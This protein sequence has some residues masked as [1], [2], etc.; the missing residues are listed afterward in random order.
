MRRELKS[1]IGGAA[2][3]V[4]AACSGGNDHN[5]DDNL[6]F[7]PPGGAVRLLTV[8]DAARELGNVSTGAIISS[9][10]TTTTTATSARVA[11]K[12]RGFAAALSMSGLAPRWQARATPSPRASSGCPGGGSDNITASGTTSRSFEFFNFAGTVNYEV[13]Q[14]SDCSG[15]IAGTTIDG[16]AQSGATAD[17]SYIYALQGDLPSATPLNLFFNA[18]D[19][20]NGQT[21]A[22]RQNVLGTI[23]AQESSAQEDLRAELLVRLIQSERG[24]RIY[25][26]DFAVG[27]ASLSFQVVSGSNSAILDGPYS[28]STS[29]AD[30]DGGGVTASTPQILQLGTTSAASNVP[31]GGTL[32]LTSGTR[33]VTYTFNPDGSVTLSGAVNGSLSSSDVANLW[34]NGAC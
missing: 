12:Q 25:D 7:Q 1:A 18:V 33:A 30:C 16:P 28:Y 21:I 31:I 5:N 32:V 34:S 22:E 10:G 17:Q 14:Y 27:D 15:L 29:L 2:A 23:E 8:D 11:T 9:L 3:L 4:L 26:G 24:D 13:H 19:N 20:I 6:V